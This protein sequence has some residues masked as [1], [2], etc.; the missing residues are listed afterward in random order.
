MA[1]A[2]SRLRI[3][4]KREGLP[5]DDQV[6]LTASLI[7]AISVEEKSPEGLK[8][9]LLALGYL[10]YYVLPG[11]EMEDL[12]KAMDAQGTVL[13]KGKLFPKEP[14]IHEIGVELLGKGIA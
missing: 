14:L 9:F 12:L 3:Q 10:V 4:E 6:E 7:E 1:A 2:N 11:S 5:E 8:G 13:G